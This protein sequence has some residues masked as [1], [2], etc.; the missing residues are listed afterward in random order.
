VRWKSAYPNATCC[1]DE[2]GSKAS[3]HARL[4]RRKGNPET[5]ATSF[6]DSVVCILLKTTLT[7]E[8]DL[9]SLHGLGPRNIGHVL[10]HYLKNLKFH[11]L[12]LLDPRTVVI[13]NWGIFWRAAVAVVHF[14][15]KWAR[16]R[17]GHAPSIALQSVSWKSRSPRSCHVQPTLLT[18]RKWPIF[19]RNL[20]TICSFS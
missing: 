10:I 15:S 12:Q 5:P 6:R 13:C 4:R 9:R 2:L 1:H 20:A 3:N 18:R 11:G 16:Q 8:E 17:G 14:L 19:N 7:F